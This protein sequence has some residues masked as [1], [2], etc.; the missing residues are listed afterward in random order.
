MNLL[1]IQT[2]QKYGGIVILAPLLAD[3]MITI[4]HAF[5]GQKK[6]IDTKL[7]EASGLPCLVIIGKREGDDA[8]KELG[9]S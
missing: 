6:V 3:D 7:Q 4:L 8:R 5:S 2:I 9:L 1:A